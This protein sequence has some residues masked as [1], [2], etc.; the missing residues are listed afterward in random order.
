MMSAAPRF[1]EGT[2]L[3]SQFILQALQIEV[4]IVDSNSFRRFWRNHPIRR[5]PA[6]LR[7]GFNN[8]LPLRFQITNSLPS[9]PSTTGVSEVRHVGSDIENVSISG[10]SRSCLNQRPACRVDDGDRYR[11]RF[12]LGK[13]DRWWIGDL[14]PI[15]NIIPSVPRPI[16][17]SSV[18]EKIVIFKPKNP[19]AN[20][21][22]IVISAGSA[23]AVVDCGGPRPSPR[24][25]DR[26]CSNLPRGKNNRVWRIWI[27]V[28]IDSIPKQP[29]RHTLKFAIG[30]VT[31]ATLVDAISY[32]GNWTLRHCR[33]IVAG[34]LAKERDLVTAQI[35]VMS[36]PPSVA[37]AVPVIAIALFYVVIDVGPLQHLREVQC[38]TVKD[39]S[40]LSV[41]VDLFVTSACN[42]RCTAHQ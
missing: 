18:L 8:A 35:A 1:R 21:L 3:C 10:V 42:R 32:K 23:V 17:H 33:R 26:I 2:A 36:L 34:H 39:D 37:I 19:R 28:I 31:R 22:V 11:N 30:G 6:S 12:Y 20:R 15:Y 27:W 25:G 14:L 38:H 13:A 40:R 29:F 16:G 9:N 24:A 41:C 7:D 4:T 5:S